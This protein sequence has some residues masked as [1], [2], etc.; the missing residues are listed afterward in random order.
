MSSAERCNVYALVCTRV[1]LSVGSFSSHKRGRN[2]QGRQLVAEVKECRVHSSGEHSDFE[3]V[4]KRKILRDKE[5]QTGKRRTRKG[6]FQ[7]A[8]L[9]TLSNC[10]RAI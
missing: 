1:I 5:K 2:H 3:A 8:V 6:D 4:G 9:A 10:Y 7:G